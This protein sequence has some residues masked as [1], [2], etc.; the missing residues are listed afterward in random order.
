MNCLTQS[1]LL[2]GLLAASYAAVAPYACR[3]N[4]AV[5]PGFERVKAVF[6]SRRAA[7]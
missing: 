4:E 6:R 1:L 5:H 3:V 2:V 7:A